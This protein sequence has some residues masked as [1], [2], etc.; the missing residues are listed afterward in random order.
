MQD[1]FSKQFTAGRKIKM[2][3]WTCS[4][5]V[6]KIVRKS[7][8]DIEDYKAWMIVTECENCGA[9]DD[10]F[11]NKDYYGYIDGGAE[12]LKGEWKL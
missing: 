12:P 6:M 9:R 3:C 11:I 5:S 8:Q 4:N 7:C 1:I 10:F 2:E